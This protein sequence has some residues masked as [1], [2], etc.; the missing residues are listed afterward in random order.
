MLTSLSLG[1]S[2]ASKRA[3][4]LARSTPSRTATNKVSSPETVPATSGNAGMVDR[5]GDEMRRAGRRL[6]HQQLAGRLDRDH[7]FAKDPLEPASAPVGAGELVGQRI[8]KGA[9]ALHLDRAQLLEVAR[10]G[11]LGDG[12]AERLEPR[13][14]LLLAGQRA[15]ADQLGERCAGAGRGCRSSPRSAR[16]ARRA[17]CACGSRPAARPR[18]W[19]CRSRRRSLPRRGGRGGS[20]GTRRRPIRP[21]APRR[22]DRGRAPHAAP[23]A[24]SSWPIDTQTSV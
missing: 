9:A 21:S 14:R 6:D 13:G 10:D 2:S 22:P 23:R 8:G 7:P 19:R 3:S 1:P 15:G 12:E 4:S 17:R 24:S 20:A 11:R 5:R 16:P 18:S